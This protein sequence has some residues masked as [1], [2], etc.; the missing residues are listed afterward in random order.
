METKT[1]NLHSTAGE[2]HY[3]PPS[4]RPQGANN[5][6][7]EHTPRPWIRHG[8]ESTLESEN[9]RA[10]NLRL[11]ADIAAVE[12]R[13]DGKSFSVWYQDKLLYVHKSASLMRQLMRN[14]ITFNLRNLA[15]ELDRCDPSALTKEV[16]QA[17]CLNLTAESLRIKAL[18][19]PLLTPYTK[20]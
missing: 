13:P 11:H 20:R 14:E 16:A 17:F 8:N 18:S 1:T 9:L 10:I 5:M 3:A 2:K 7:T 15:D 19:K 6:E 4:T 12:I